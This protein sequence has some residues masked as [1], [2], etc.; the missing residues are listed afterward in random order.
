MAL[1]D[2]EI[3]LIESV[4]SDMVPVVQELE[5]QLSKKGFRI[6]VSVID[7][8]ITVLLSHRW[9]IPIPLILLRI[10]FVNQILKPFGYRVAKWVSEKGWRRFGVVKDK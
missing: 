3:Y 9:L 2:K 6:E 1:T 8:I 5:W 10:D 4:D 7:G